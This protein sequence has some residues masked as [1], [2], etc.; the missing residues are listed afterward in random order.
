MKIKKFNESEYLDEIKFGPF[1]TSIKY[2]F[3][4]TNAK[5]GIYYH[6]LYSEEKNLD[7]AIKTFNNLCNDNLSEDTFFVE[8]ITTKEFSKQDFEILI[9]K[10]KYNL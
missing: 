8:E 6:E 1:E 4:R 9:N 10:N 7:N 3:Y 5:K 2:N